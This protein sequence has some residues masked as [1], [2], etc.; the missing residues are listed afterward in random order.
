MGNRMNAVSQALLL[1]FGDFTLDPLRRVLA[2]RD[3]EPIALTPKHFDTLL[4]LVENPGQV[5]GKDRMMAAIWPGT[6]VEE[7][8]LSQAISHL[9]RVL[10]DDGEEHR[11]ILTVPRQ[12][13]RFV[14]PVEAVSGSADAPALA[15]TRSPVAAV[16]PR[17]P[18]AAVEP[19]SPVAAAEPR[20]PVAAVE[21]QRSRYVWV[22]VGLAI[23]L[24]LVLMPFLLPK[25]VAE[26]A[27]VE[28]TAA[29]PA[30]EATQLARRAIALTTKLGFR[31]EDL[32]VAADLARKASELDSALALAWGARGRVEASWIL[33]A[34][35]AS[36]N[37]RQAAQDHAKRALALDPAEPN[38]LWSQGIV[39]RTQGA[40]PEAVALL[41]RAVKSAPEDN[42]IR[43]TL[44]S[45][46]WFQGREDPGRRQEA[47][48]TYEEVL[49]RDPRDA[50]ALYGLAGTHASFLGLRDDNPANVDIAL[51]YLDRA[52]EIQVF[53]GALES[54]A[55]YLAAWKGDL[56]AA[57]TTLDRA[58][59]MPLEDATE[60]LMVSF[61]MWI[62]LLERQPA[63][64]L[65][66]A[67]RTTTTYFEHGNVA[68]PVAWMKALAHKQAGRGS[69]A[70]EEWRAAEAVL[71]ARL[72]AT[73]NS[74]L[75]QAQLAVTL[76]MLDQKDEAARQFARF[77]AAQREQ[78]RTGTLHQV[79]FHAAMGDAK[80]AAAALIEARKGKSIWFTDAVLARDPWFDRLRGKPEFEA[81]LKE[82]ATSW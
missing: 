68:Q 23:G 72:T 1:G 82:S 9:R 76:A 20:A 48:A 80:R 58:A 16:E 57:R 50:L 46:L 2:R 22:G 60:D 28:T 41:R 62:A 65:A 73:P 55:A 49:R 40:T 44:A 45:T 61:Q 36:H 12:G 51:A 34:W 4:F 26:P 43:R 74:L 27:A 3:G 31:R 21:P 63:R 64:A 6:V 77:D 18:V 24:V 29:A 69:A 75:T 71:R 56:A 25:R 81:L 79:R 15:P 39:L 66:A 14:A 8:N 38:A 33:R 67:A 54:K 78:G 5:L 52:L 59:T 13:Y 17:S 42:A 47:I 30:S 11:Y 37:R 53:G 7:N 19:R 10:G 70:A 32:T 35:D